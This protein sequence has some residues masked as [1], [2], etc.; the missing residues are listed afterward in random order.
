MSLLTNRPTTDDKTTSVAPW[1]VSKTLEA[2]IEMVN[3]RSR[4][5]YC[6]LALLK[7]LLKSQSLFHSNAER[8]RVGNYA[9]LCGP[10]T[11]L[12]TLHIS[13]T[14]ADRLFNLFIDHKL[15]NIYFVSGLIARSLWEPGCSDTNIATN[16]S[17]VQKYCGSREGSR[18]A[19]TVWWWEWSYYNIL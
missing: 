11:F 18:E 19:G 15:L 7:I 16:N 5:S 6:L 14:S 8:V 12:S 13:G 9:I 17:N 10:F 4:F 1:V 3:P 2:N